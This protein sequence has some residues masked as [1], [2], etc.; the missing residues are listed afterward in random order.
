[1]E[2]PAAQPQAELSPAS[3]APVSAQVVPITQ[4]PAQ[5]ALIPGISPEL[6]TRIAR[7]AQLAQSDPEALKALVV[8]SG[9]L[10]TQYAAATS[11]ETIKQARATAT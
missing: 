1:M 8:L 6:L 2:K 3:L 10:S 4:P 5:E 11:R 7:L 9:Q